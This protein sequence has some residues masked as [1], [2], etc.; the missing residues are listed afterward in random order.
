MTEREEKQVADDT[1]GEASRRAARCAFNAQLALP[2]DAALHS[3]DA[4]WDFCLTG[5]QR[6]VRESLTGAGITDAASHDWLA[7][8]AIDRF[9]A[10]YDR[11]NSHV[12]EPVEAPDA[13]H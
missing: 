10:E 2:D 8:A 5:L 11:L 9:V 7:N 4:I 13:L 6:C 12:I 3:Y 1:V